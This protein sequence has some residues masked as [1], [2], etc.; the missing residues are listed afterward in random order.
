MHEVSRPDEAAAVSGGDGPEMWDAVLEL[1]RGAGTITI[2]GHTNPDGDAI[3]SVLA[4][5]MAIR[6]AW[7][8]KEVALLLADDQ[9]VPRI[10]RF[11]ACSD[12]MVPARGYHE[13]PD[14]FIAVDS[15]SLD[16]LRDAAEVARRARATA[17]IDHHPAPSE[18][19][20]VVVRRPQAAAAAV[21]IADLMASSGMEI[22]PAIADC[23][24]TGL[25]TDTGRFQYQNADEEAF[26]CA[27]LLVASGAD[28]AHVASEVYQSERVGYLKLEGLVMDRIGLAAEGRIAYSYATA[29]DLAAYGVEHDECD[30][31]I[32]AVRRVGGV[33]VCLFC[34]EGR[35]PGIVR[36]SLRAKDGHDVS[37]VAARFGGGG[38]AAAAGFSFHG[39]VQE[40]L[41]A[42][43]PEL[44]ALL[45]ED[46][47]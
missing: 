20:D 39:T 47:R 1:I 3:G 38:H 33:Q 40:A 42:V 41:D 15:P 34:K 13:A 31:L 45:A 16:R 11:L 29:A 44:E 26:R 30:G 24:F 10:Y 36:G 43:L 7:P 2:S 8:G 14:L 6:G 4:L 22:T 27:S 23:L 32:D 28:P 21:L 46:E 9:P 12:E 37:H 25:V 19:A 17:V 35:T 5:G 18:F